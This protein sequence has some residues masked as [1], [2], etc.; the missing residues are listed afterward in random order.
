MKTTTYKTMHSFDLGENCDNT[1]LVRF[2]QACQA[3]QEETGESDEVVTEWMWGNGDWWNRAK[4][5]APRG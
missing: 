1:D 4:R 3:R 2:V 5:Y